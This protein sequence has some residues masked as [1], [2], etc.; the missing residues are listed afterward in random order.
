[1]YDFDRQY[2]SRFALDR[3]LELS[4]EDP[5]GYDISDEFTYDAEMDMFDDEKTLDAQD[6][7][8]GDGFLFEN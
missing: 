7:I 1:M 4:W 8:P 2:L 6:P 3:D 5:Y